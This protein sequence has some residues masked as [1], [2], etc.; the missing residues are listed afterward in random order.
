MHEIPENEKWGQP[1]IFL[2]HLRTAF[3]M[4]IKKI[5]GFLASSLLPWHLS[6]L[7]MFKVME[8]EG[9]FLGKFLCVGETSADL[10][11]GMGEVRSGVGMQRWKTKTEQSKD[12]SSVSLFPPSTGE[13]P[14]PFR[15]VAEAHTAVLQPLFLP[16]PPKQMWD[17]FCHW[18]F[19]VQELQMIKLLILLVFR[20][21]S[22]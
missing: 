11:M 12:L 7:C 21:V 15:P 16:S 10:Y 22:H 2:T 4:H 3:V 9:L 13:L 8:V 19:R 18:D 6:D 1:I 17:A 5:G 20:G 14:V